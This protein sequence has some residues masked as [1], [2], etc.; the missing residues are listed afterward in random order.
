MSGKGRRIR[1]QV[2]KE[3]NQ[4]KNSEKHWS[5]IYAITCD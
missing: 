3:K 2:L 4:K 5:N 1:E